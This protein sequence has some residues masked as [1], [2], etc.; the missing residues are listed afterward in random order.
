MSTLRELTIAKLIQ[1]CGAIEGRVKLQ[2]V[3]YLLIAIGYRFPYRDFRIQHYGPF[4]PKLAAAMDFLVRAG[5]VEEKPE[6]LGGDSPRYDYTV[7]DRWGELLSTYVEIETPE[8]RG[9]LE[10]D[11][12]R[13]VN[14][15]RSTLEIAATMCF[16]YYEE[17][18]SEGDL[19]AELKSLKGHLQAFDAKV[20]E[21]EQ[22][23]SQ[24][25]LQVA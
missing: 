11:A 5:V 17:G 6:E 10:D 4:S 2:K 20:R 9:P 1:A 14:V 18:C 7:D 8:G 22:L 13:L 23:L 21:A 24:L 16:L 25:D 15:D 19:S 12:N 3:V